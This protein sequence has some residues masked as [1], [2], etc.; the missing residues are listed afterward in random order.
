MWVRPKDGI[1]RL[2]TVSDPLNG[3][4]LFRFNIKS[5]RYPLRRLDELRN[6]KLT[7]PKETGSLTSLLLRHKDPRPR[8]ESFQ[9]STPPVTMDGLTF[10]E[11]FTPHENVNKLP[12]PCEVYSPGKKVDEERS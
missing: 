7:F 12:S 9:N 10:R 5:G 1:H 8:R 2:Q 3:G 11:N 4:S 6:P